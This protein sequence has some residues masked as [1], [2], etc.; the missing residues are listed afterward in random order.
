M[1]F[2]DNFSKYYITMEEFVNYYL[3]LSDLEEQD[4]KNL[5]HGTHQDLTSLGIENVKR[6]PF[7]YIHSSDIYNG[8]ILLVRSGKNKNNIAPY[9]RPSLIL[10]SNENKTK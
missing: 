5:I 6:I 4:Y 8:N 2:I 9:I 10:N 7:E 3:G 1:G